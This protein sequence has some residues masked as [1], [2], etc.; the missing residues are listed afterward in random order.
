MK[1]FFLSIV[2]LMMAFPAWAQEP[3]Q[4]T[5]NA[6][7][8]VNSVPQPTTQRRMRTIENREFDDREKII[9]LLNAH[10]DF[11]SKEDLLATSPDVESILHDI[12]MD[13][14][15]LFSVRLRAVEA[16]SYFESPKNIEML[17]WILANP[18]KVKHSLMLM[19]A[20]RAYPK[21]APQQAPA[22]LAPFLESENDM[23]RFVTISSLKTCPGEAAI[24]VLSDRYSVETNRFFQFRLKDAI[25]NHCQESACGK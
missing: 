16:L 15:V 10:C 23:V 7:Q 20:I 21:V 18:E 8:S 13:K 12:L 6:E 9:L 11:P 14:S 5:N 22:A 1:A 2:L 3:A 4:Q 17:E 19:Q 24:R 25:D